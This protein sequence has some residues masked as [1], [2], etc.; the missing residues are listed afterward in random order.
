ME[1]NVNK[2]YACLLNGRG[3]PRYE[4]L[5]NHD[6]PKA[7]FSQESSRMRWLASSPRLL[8]LCSK[9]KNQCGVQTLR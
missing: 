6:Q 5:L 7:H 4:P 2:R 8:R 9:G 3:L 1:K